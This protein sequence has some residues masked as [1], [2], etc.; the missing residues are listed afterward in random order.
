MRR[1]YITWLLRKILR[2]PHPVKILYKVIKPL[3]L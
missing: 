2:R 1:S 3:E